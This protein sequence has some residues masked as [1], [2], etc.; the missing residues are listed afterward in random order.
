M[1]HRKHTY[2]IARPIEVPDSPDTRLAADMPYQ[3]ALKFFREKAKKT[4][5]SYRL[6]HIIYGPDGEIERREPGKI[7]IRP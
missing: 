2:Y 1:K 4:G 5:L 7:I 6:D 3:E